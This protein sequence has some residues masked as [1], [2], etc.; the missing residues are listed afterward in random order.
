MLKKSC[1]LTALLL[2]AELLFGQL[3]YKLSL[4]I[5]S[6]KTLDQTTCEIYRKT[7]N[8]EIDTISIFRAD[9]IRAARFETNYIASMQILIDFGFPDRK[10]VGVT[11][12]CNFWLIVQHMDNHV[13]FQQQVLDSMTTRLAGNLIDSLNWVFL[14]DRVL[15]NSG[16]AQIYGTQTKID[17]NPKRHVIKNTIDVNNLNI[18]RKGVGL[19]PIEKYLELMDRRYY[20]ELKDDY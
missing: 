13:D 4:T 19:E 14:T 17:G 7:K 10:K 8:G 6:L 12:S 5:D 20:G 16:K 9:S 2:F 1:S 3:N 15:I 18:R 11:S